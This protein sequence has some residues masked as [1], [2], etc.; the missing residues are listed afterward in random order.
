MNNR[1]LLIAGA[2]VAVT[3]VLLWLLLVPAPQPSLEQ[4]LPGRI[5]THV[6]DL[7]ERGLELG[8]NGDQPQ[9]RPLRPD[10][11]C[12]L[13]DSHRQAEAMRQAL[14]QRGI[15]SRLRPF[16]RV[17]L[18]YLTLAQPLVTL[19]GGELQRLRLAQA[20]AGGSAGSLYVLDEP[21]V[22]LH[23]R[24]IH[25]LIAT[26]G[27]LR[28]RGNTVVVVEHDLDVIRAADHVV[29][30]GPGAAQQAQEEGLHLV[31]EVMPWAIALAVA[32]EDYDRLPR[33][34]SSRPTSQRKPTLVTPSPIRRGT[35]CSEPTSSEGMYFPGFFSARESHFQSGCSVY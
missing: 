5:A 19:S 7:L 29:E 20:L 23:H 17:G 18:G 22:G 27:R 35:T 32:T 21:S 3:A 10:D 2:A 16:A 12:L 15:A 28:D 34:L 6:V 13:V 26:L 9:R 8:R 4:E 30:L 33:R 11:I 14:E 24:D 31:V 25:R 1:V